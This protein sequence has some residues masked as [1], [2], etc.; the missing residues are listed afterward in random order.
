MKN[1]LVPIDF[2]ETTEAVL[3]YAIDF[4]KKFESNL[5]V[6]HVVPPINLAKVNPEIYTAPSS[7]GELAPIITPMIEYN[8][9]DT[10][11]EIAKRLVKEHKKMHN[12][13]D[14]LLEKGLKVQSLLFEGE[15]LE[16]ILYQVKKKKADMIILGSHGHSL[17]HKALLG[18]TA[19]GILRNVSCP[20]VIIPPKKQKK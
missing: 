9:Q 6:I 18:S 12:V 7:F 10:R 2:S 15:I 3:D 8:L 5:I 14:K 11:K 16:T 1:I 4:A 20:V 17:L 13:H 19:D